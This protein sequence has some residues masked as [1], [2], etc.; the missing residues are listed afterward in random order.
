MALQCSPHTLIPAYSGIIATEVGGDPKVTALVYIAAR[1][2]D[3]G[4]GYTG[5]A[6][7]Y[8][9]PPASAGLVKALASTRRGG[10]R[11]TV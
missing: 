6:A 8:P 7:Q 3:A 5:L 11:I 2:P 4:E 9:T 1:A 10:N